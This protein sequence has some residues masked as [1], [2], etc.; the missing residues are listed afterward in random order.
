MYVA[1]FEGVQS[2]KKNV[3]NN[4]NIYGQIINLCRC[5]SIIKNAQTNI[6]FYQIDLEL[7]SYELICI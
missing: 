2:L 5:S 4:N 7:H 3:N 6:S 1:L